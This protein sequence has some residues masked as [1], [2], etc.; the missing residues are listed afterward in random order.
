MVLTNIFAGFGGQ[1]VLLIGKLVA[2]AGMD[3][4]R[5]V[6]WLPSY[7]PE[8]RGG[9]ANCSVVVSDD[10]IASPVLSMADCVIAMN[11]PSLDKF[12]A[13]VLPGG[14]LFINSSIIDKK[15]TRTDIDVYYVPCNDIAD[16]LGNPKVLNMAMLGAYLEATKVVGVESV[17]QALLHSLGEKKAHLIPLNRQAIE[18]GAESIRK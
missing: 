15:A 18:M 5:N 8:M 10:P 16:Q 2:Y 11:T 14:K 17:L 9:T 6:S 7:G 1:G 4:G 12:E 3:E 13:N